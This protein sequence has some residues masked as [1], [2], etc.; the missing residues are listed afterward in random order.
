MQ[1]EVQPIPYK[2]RRSSFRGGTQNQKTHQKI[3]ASITMPKMLGK[4]LE[5]LILHSMQNQSLP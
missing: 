3:K 5:M 4:L 2:L 1:E